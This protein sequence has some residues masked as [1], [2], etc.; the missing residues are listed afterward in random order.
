MRKISLIISVYN[1]T[2]SLELILNALTIQD[3]SNFEILIADDGSDE[4][5]HRFISGFR[6]KTGLDIKH[7]FQEDNG[8]RKTR[9][10]NSAIKKSETS[11]L[12]FI[13]GDCI[14][15]SRFISQHSAHKEHNTVL[16]GRRVNLS[17]KFSDSITV[18]NVLN[19]EVEKI[20][21]SHFIDSIRKREDRTTYIE[22]GLFLQNSALRKLLSK[23]APHIVG[24]NF[25]LYKKDIERING[26]D[27]N[28]TGPGFGEDSD[29]E[30]RLRLSGCKFKSIRNLAILFHMYHPLTKQSMDNSSYF[31]DIVSKS[32]D[33]I[34]KN[35][36]QKL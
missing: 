18:E 21:L 34:C 17:K 27:E 23:S 8:F 7:I 12:V 10:L 13:D 28:Y 14:P 9:I 16:C 20:K 29:I 4:D 24:C 3:E 30:Y 22:E 6:K 36:L 32:S 33:S 35:G 26:F 11:Y 31:F 2:R 19:G 1:N 25:S 15:H 5:M